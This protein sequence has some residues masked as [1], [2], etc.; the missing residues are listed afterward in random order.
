MAEEFEER[1]AA[2][3]TARTYRELEALV[4]DLPGPVRHRARRSPPALTA[5]RWAVTTVRAY[6][7]LG[8]V[9]IPVLAVTLAMII[10]VTLL[11][12]LLVAVAVILGGRSRL[13]PWTAHGPRR[14]RSAR[15]PGGSWI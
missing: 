2:A 6:P 1:V 13:G 12:T 10:A 11:W 15:R 9:L 7:M 14:L 5:G 3:L 4:A 8:L